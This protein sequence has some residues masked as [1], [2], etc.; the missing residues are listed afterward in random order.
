VNKVIEL[1]RAELIAQL[2]WA[3]PLITEQVLL[4]VAAVPYGGDDQVYIREATAVVK[5][6]SATALQPMLDAMKAEATAAR[7][8]ADALE[9]EH[10]RQL[11]KLEDFRNMNTF[12]TVH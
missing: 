2:K 10:A 9:A 11:R 3:G 6:A 12:N 1:Y 5:E 8:K 7:A 4:R